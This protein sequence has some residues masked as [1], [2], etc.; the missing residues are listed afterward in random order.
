M[1]GPFF[2][3][4]GHDVIWFATRADAEGYLEVYDVGS[5]RFFAKDGRELVVR[6]N[7]DNYSVA[8]T[9]E[10]VGN[11]PDQLAESLRTYLQASPKKHRSLDAAAVQSA[12]LAELVDAMV[13]S[14][15][16]H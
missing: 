4:D 1:E 8:I 15:R 3:V 12:T 10:A 9:E 16:G 14:E 5:Y 6:A 13:R 11:F 2:C 7:W